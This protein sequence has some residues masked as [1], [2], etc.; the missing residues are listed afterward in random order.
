MIFDGDKHQLE[1]YVRE[2]ADLCGLRD[3]TITLS[4]EPIEGVPH[5]VGSEFGGECNVIY[6][7]KYA[8]IKLA[9]SWPRWEPEK[10][11]T[12]VVH[13]LTHCHTIPME[14]ALNGAQDH[15]APAMF[16]LLFGAHRDFHELAVDGISTAWAERLPLPI[17][18]GGE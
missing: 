9:D 12:T 5:S 2:M 17:L 14:W 16:S 3:W 15:L 11:R 10:L 18:S 13:E 4:D 6:G 1:R 7:S 8:V